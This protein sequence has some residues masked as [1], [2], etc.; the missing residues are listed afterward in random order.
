MEIYTDGACEMSTRRGGWAMV[1]VKDDEVT[2][3]EWGN[4]KGTT[5]NIMELTALMTGLKVA[6]GYLATQ[7]SSEKKFTPITIFTDS[8]YCSKGYNE[9]CKGWE[10]KNWKNSQKKTVENLELWKEIHTLRHPYIKIEWV[11]GH[12]GNKWNEYCDSLTRNYE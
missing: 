6:L 3:E 1:V 4:A 10:K 2:Y 11:R 8:Q 7:S 12:D 5:N 9:W